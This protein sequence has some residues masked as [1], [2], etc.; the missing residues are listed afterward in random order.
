MPNKR[1]SF[2]KPKS[3]PTFDSPEELFSKLPNR[4]R[5]HGYLRGPQADALR[6]YATFSDKIDIAFELPTGTGKTMVGL[7]VAEWRRRLT[8]EKVAY[9]ALTNQLAKQVLREA[10]Q[11]GIVC[12]DLTGTKDTR[13]PGEVGRYQTARAIGVTTYANLFNVNPV[14]QASNVLVL[15]DAHGGEQYVAAM[16][17]VRIDAG[18]HPNTY[19]EVLTALRPALTEAQYRAVTDESAFS[20]VEL[21]DVHTHPDVLINVTAVLDEA[22]DASIHFPWSAMRNNLHACLFLNK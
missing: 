20:A 2:R 10:A 21:A 19:S 17:T 8:T 13:D 15:D 14:V 3:P 12:A 7:L 18:Q 5:T 9:L 1:P 4:A 6:E 11:L 16:W 22:S